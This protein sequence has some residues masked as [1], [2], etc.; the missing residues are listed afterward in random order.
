MKVRWRNLLGFILILL[1]LFYSLSQ[2]RHMGY[3]IREIHSQDAMSVSSAPFIIGLLS[4][5][6]LIMSVVIL[7]KIILS[8]E[9]SV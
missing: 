8:R 6:I 5:I 7:V 9:E 1:G 4:I 3:F 2:R